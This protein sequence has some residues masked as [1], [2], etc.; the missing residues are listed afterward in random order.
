MLLP[1]LV[2]SLGFR[3]KKE[4]RAMPQTESYDIF[5]NEEGEEEEEGADTEMDEENNSNNKSR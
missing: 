3:T 4:L 2:L 1:P 5:G